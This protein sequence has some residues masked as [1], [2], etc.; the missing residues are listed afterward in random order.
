MN[1]IKI[2]MKLVIGFSVMLCLLLALGT[3]SIIS[4]NKIDSVV[5]EYKDHELPS[6]SLIWKMRRNMVSIQ[7]NLLLALVAPDSNTIEKAINSALS[8]RQS[9]MAAR[10]EFRN[11]IDDTTELDEFSKYLEDAAIYRKQIEELSRN[12]NE[13]SN[14]EA[15]NIFI[16]KYSP[17]YENASKVLISLSD[18]LDTVI[19]TQGIK[20]SSNARS[21]LITILVSIFASLIIAVIAIAVL[22]KAIAN[23][24]IELEAAAGQIAKG[25]LNVNLRASGNDEI[26]KLVLAF[27]KVRD[28]IFLLTEKI[29][30]VSKKLG[31]G[32]IEAEIDINQFEG[33]YKTVVSAV[34]TNTRTLIDDTLKILSA[35]SQLGEGNFNVEI[36]K[37]PGK[38]A[39][40][41]EK[42]DELKSNLATLNK[43]VSSLIKAAMEGKLDTRVNTDAYKGD[44]KALTEGLNNLLKSISTP[45]DEANLVLRQISEGN[46]NVSVS[47]NYNGSFAEMMSSF[48][49]MI[50]S[51]SSYITEITEVLKSLSDGDLRKSI[52]RDYVGQYNL[53]K[54]SINN[55][56]ATL[57]DTISEII[58]SADNVL[59][60]AKQISES[61][62]DLANG[63]STQAS[64]VEELN[65][66]ITV[67]NEQTQATA[68]KAQTADDF[69]KKSISSAKV[70]NEEMTRMLHSMD[71]IKEASK[72]ISKIIKVI[73]DIAFQTNLLAL[74]A[75]VEAARAGQHGKGFA[76]V[77]EEVRSLAGRSQQAAKDT[78]DLI[79]DTIAKINEG[80]QTAKLT[81]DSLQTIV[82]DTNSVSDIINDIYIATKEQT[83]GIA[84]ITLGIH[85]I[86]DVVQR[87]SSTSEETAAAAEEL[88]SQSEVLAQMVSHFLV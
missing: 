82:S 81:A 36:E 7:R 58:I 77:A 88:S 5:L 53:I 79:E 8:D 70:G 73:D 3:V 11:I 65:A 74:N 56:A 35:Y 61:S 27:A 71:D 6:I 55:I 30:D 68:V 24:M 62:M 59:V 20:A 84:Q 75:A 54:H 17:A 26:G 2:K 16:E 41:N 25:N 63:A 29:N 37:F 48:N 42:Y 39:L 66:S 50:T 44:W 32:D 15:Y 46:F 4:I 1:N 9:L 83:N 22:N 69:S 51:I 28:T 38:K 76:V 31:Q 23:P 18:E 47:N 12:N 78:S 52:T 19:A 14:K 64:S 85:Q 67:I 13:E 34:N 43:D 57:R 49:M 72:N 10:D 60:G 40:A 45:I 86:S 21:A 80:T 33:E 87:N